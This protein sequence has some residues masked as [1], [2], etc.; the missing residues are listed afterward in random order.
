MLTRALGGITHA[1]TVVSALKADK[2]YDTRGLESVVPLIVTRFAPTL[3][4]VQDGNAERSFSSV[5]CRVRRLSNGV[6]THRFKPVS[7]DAVTAL[8]EKHG[9]DPSMPVV[10]HVGHLE[11]N[12][13]LGVLSR[14][15]E[16]GIQ[17]LIAGSLYMGVHAHLI[18]QLEGYGFHI[19]KG[20]QPNVEE[21]YQLADCY[22]FP[23]P[24]GNSLTT[25]LSVLEAMSSNLAVVATRFAG[26]TESFAPGNGLT[27]VDDPAAV[28]EAVLQ[29]LQSRTTVRTR[30]L[31]LPH[32]WAAVANTLNRYYEELLVA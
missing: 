16:L 25:P 21:L 22:V 2:L 27:F 29:M 1:K 8:R 20:Y 31:A 19:L 6:D 5:G 18:R 9:L 12:R 14:L 7:A 17:V 23:V 13:N 3:I 11:E 26:L 15:P 10:L 28:P 4:L 24:P 30:E 32:S